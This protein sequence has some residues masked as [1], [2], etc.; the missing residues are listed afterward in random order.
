MQKWVRFGAT[1]TI[2]LCCIMV[3][4]GIE[5]IVQGNVVH[6]PNEITGGIILTP[7]FIVVGTSIFFFFKLLGAWKRGAAWDKMNGGRKF[8]LFLFTLPGGILSIFTVGIFIVLF[9]AAIGAGG[10][11]ARDEARE[12]Q[13]AEF[14]SDVEIGVRNALKRKGFK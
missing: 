1:S 2:V 12:A 7:F 9:G 3:L 10:G 13:R 6:D 14:R 8:L 4:F 11:F 5:Q